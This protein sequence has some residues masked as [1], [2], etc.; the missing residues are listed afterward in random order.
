MTGRD[1]E[2]VAEASDDPAVQ[3]ML[4]EL[5]GLPEPERSTSRQALLDYLNQGSNTAQVP[6]PSDPNQPAELKAQL[7]AIRKKADRT[8][9]YD[10]VHELN[11]ATQRYYAKQSLAAADPAFV[12]KHLDTLIKIKKQQ[13]KR[14]KAV[15]E[16]T[17]IGQRG[18]NELIDR[19]AMDAFLDLHRPNLARWNALLER[20]TAD[21]VALITDNRFHLA[22][23]Y[24]DAQQAEQIGLAFSAQ[25]ACFKDICRSD[26]AIADIHAWLEKQPY[27]DRPLFYSLPLSSQTE[28]IGQLSNLNNAGYNLVTKLQDWIDQLRASE[29]RHLPALD[30]LPES[31][32]VIGESAHQT[33]NPALAYGMSN[34]LESFFQSKA[35]QQLPTLDELFRKL[36][37]ALPARLLDA[38]RIDGVTFTA[39]SP[40]ELAALR[41]TIGDVLGE[42]AE[43]SRL[44]RER[45]RVKRNSGHKSARAQ[46]L[47]AEIRRVRSELSVLEQRLAQGLSPIAEL[48]DNSMRVVGAAP[49]RA[50]IT[51]VFPAAAQQQEVG[52]VLS[53]VRQGYTHASAKGVLGDGAGLL[54]FLAQ[55]VNLVQVWRETIAK[56]PEQR[57]WSAFR[58]ALIATGS[59]GF[60]A[61]QSIADTAL[62]ARSA[63]L[64]KAL[65]RHTLEG[66]HA[67]MGKLHVLLGGIGYFV[68]LGASAISLSAHQAEWS[69]AVRQG[70]SRAQS[71]AVLSMAGAAG[72]VGSNTYGLGFTAKAGYDVWRGASWAT[73]GTRLSTVF[74]R[75]NLLGA[76]FTLL[77]LG[78]TWWYN[79]HNISRH[80]AWLLS[81]PWGND[82]EQRQALPLATY[83]ERLQTIAHT[84]NAEVKHLGHGNWLRD[85]V[86]APKA[87]DITLSLPG[88]TEAALQAPLGGQPVIRLSLAAYQIFTRTTG[89]GRVRRRQVSW[90][91]ASEPVFSSAQLAQAA[92][93]L[94]QI[95]PPANTEDAS[96]ME[97]LLALRIETRNPQGQYQAQAHM[98]R[99]Q[100]D[101][102][103]NYSASQQTPQGS[104]PWLTFD[105]LLLPVTGQS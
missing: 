32:R 25:Y 10:I 66:V 48:P 83:Q 76:A 8:N 28:L 18:I 30:Q 72:M 65:Q 29:A 61:A 85:M 47:L 99:L 60:M 80:D 88:L 37:K 5:E 95:S 21:R 87:I 86:S 39:A 41:T 13:N 59:S 14:V 1:L 100:P 22:A 11:A 91:A 51:V 44:N 16:G 42:R 3:A 54:V 82:P 103:G 58:V 56:V 77:E 78:G 4:N 71:G 67:Q 19:P 50:G 34:A 104:A 102:Q 6:G 24:Y 105:S 62:T 2:Q 12:D 36:P 84:P 89:G 75:F 43:L 81:T 23:W 9:F 90:V 49:L 96:T 46:Q 94:L 26:K 98:I 15:L 69:E 97:L 27:Y 31:V 45:E 93:L 79:H 52:R 64:V 63:Q 57:D 17:K 20:I 70:N 38:A 68:G 33:L 7:D 101:D 73:A 92:P 74:F 53:S 35:S 40:E 55:V